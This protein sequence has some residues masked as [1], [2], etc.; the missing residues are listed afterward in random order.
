MRTYTIVSLGQL[1]DTN[2][3]RTSDA[4]TEHFKQIEEKRNISISES[5]ILTQTSEK[6]TA[7]KPEIIKRFLQEIVSTFRVNGF[8]RS[9]K[10]TQQQ[11]NTNNKTIFREKTRELFGVSLEEL[12]DD[13]F[14][15]LWTKMCLVESGHA[16]RIK[17]LVALPNT[18]FHSGTNA[19]QAE[20]ILE[21]L[22]KFNVEIPRERLFL[23]YE[24]ECEYTLSAENNTLIHKIHAAL[25]V[26]A[27]DNVLLIQGNNDKVPPIFVPV[28]KERYK[29]SEN[30]A[31]SLWK[32]NVTIV[33]WNN[34][35]T[36]EN[37]KPI[38]LIK[39]LQNNQLLEAPLAF[40]VSSAGDTDLALATIDKLNQLNPD[41]SLFLIPLTDTAAKRTEKVADYI[42]RHTLEEISGQSEILKGKNI[43]GVAL[44]KIKAFIDENN[45]HHAYV[46]VPSAIDDES[47]LQVTKHIDISCTLVY[48]FMFK[49]ENHVLW[50]YL[51]QFGEKKNINFAVPLAPASDDIKKIL[52]KAK[53]E[54]VG[55]LSIDRALTLDTATEQQIADVK[56]SLHLDPDD[57]LAFVSGT[58]QPTNVDIEFIAA[59]LETLNSTH[60]P[61]LHVR[62][63]IHPGIKDECV[64]DYF[65]QLL[66]V[67]KCYPKTNAQFK[68]IL[69]PTFKQRL[70]INFT[71]EDEFFI[72]HSSVSGADA[73]KAADKLAQAVPGALLNE[74]AIKGKPSYFH[75]KNNSPY[76]PSAFFEQTIPAFLSAQ[77][78]APQTLDRLQLK[79]GDVAT[80]L[81]SLGRK[82]R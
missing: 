58:T 61:N 34:N 48:E 27:D 24:Q 53:T 71:P 25:N 69:T 29:D 72:V 78:Q 16:Q 80:R 49:P 45:I 5:K 35:Q 28:S 23:S 17:E 13:R 64:N 59:L 68:I 73:A 63:G 75:L 67:C 14:D 81:A 37:G 12:D 77:K 70:N 9:K 40:F 33:G 60:Y 39:Y 43:S 76:L 66:K 54:A 79:E 11:I 57:A 65:L 52:P 62:F 18:L 19:I 46:G 42:Y 20:Y 32:E 51:A 8:F 15:A 41:R 50:Q 82:I 56:K 47:A 3:S 44:D 6:I 7:I 38:S 55:H 22:K 31:I 2:F 10:H 4:L 26:Q 1:I 74:S 36:D 21:Q 30:A